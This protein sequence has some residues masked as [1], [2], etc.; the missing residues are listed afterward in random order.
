MFVLS[1]LQSYIF[2]GQVISESL[3]PLQDQIY[4]MGKFQ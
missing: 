1:I 3:S 4:I 2:K